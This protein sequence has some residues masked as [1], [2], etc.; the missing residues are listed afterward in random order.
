MKKRVLVADDESVNSDFFGIMLSNLNFIV[1]KAEDGEKVLELIKENKPDIIIIDDML[2]VMTGWQVV[3][4]IKNDESY[5]NYA[6]IP[7][8][9]LS[10]MAEPQAI[11]EG[12]DIGI[13]D[14]IKKPFSFAIVYARIRAALRNRALLYK[15]AQGERAIALIKSIKDTVVFLEDHLV[16]PAERLKSAIDEFNK[17]DKIDRNIIIPLFNENI[18]KI[19]AVVSSISDRLTEIRKGEIELDD[20]HVDIFNLEEEYR[21]HLKNLQSKG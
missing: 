4:T 14:Y 19:V 21:K 12:F 18:D 9:M 13:D 16:S 10:D 8:I 17:N 20:M 7:I 5:R 15:K 6:D 1:D 3:K 11:V 2:P